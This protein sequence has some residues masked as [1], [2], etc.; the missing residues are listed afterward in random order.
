MKLSNSW[1]AEPACLL[2]VSQILGVILRCDTVVFK[3]KGKERTVP[4]L[5]T[6]SYT[7]TYQSQQLNILSPPGDPEGIF[8]GSLSI[9]VNSQWIRWIKIFQAVCFKCAHISLR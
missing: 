3:R 8:Y 4:Q 6:R 1:H 7:Y 9:T 5:S 2:N